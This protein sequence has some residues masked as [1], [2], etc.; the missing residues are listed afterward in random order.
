MHP[1][2]TV[3]ETVTPYVEKRNIHFYV[4]RC[5]FHIVEYF[6]EHHCDPNVNDGEMSD[7]FRFEKVLPTSSEAIQEQIKRVKYYED[8]MQK[9][10]N[11]EQNSPELCEMLKELRAYYVSDAWKRDFSA[12]EAGLLPQELK[13]GVLSEDGIYDLL[14]KYAM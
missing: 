3:W 13:R 5:G 8:I 6:S 7:M 4:N 9:I 2:V 11:S 12:D 10:M 14:E 1:E